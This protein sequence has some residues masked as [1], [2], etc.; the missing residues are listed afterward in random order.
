[1]AESLTLANLLI[2]VLAGFISFVSPCVLPLVPAFAAFLAST[3]RPR[4]E[5]EDLGAERRVT[6]RAGL[7][8]ILGFS[9]VFISLGASAPLVG[10]RLR[11]LSP[12][13]TRVGG[14]FLILLGLGMLGRWLHPAMEREYRI[15]PHRIAAT[16][17]GA[18]LIGITFAAGWTPCIGPVLAGILT[19]AASSDSSGQGAILL[20]AY[21]AGLGVP[22]LITTILVGRWQASPRRL[23]RIGRIG[24]ALAGVM[25]LVVGLL[26]VTDSWT[27][28]N[29]WLIDIAPWL[30]K[31]G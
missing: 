13:I 10:D 23:Q 18:F 4:G 26:L 22:F 24:Q 29:A 11:D 7:L 25:L 1:M 9:L 5:Q 30:T 31:I 3:I 28:L 2:A 12:W 19:L 17:L 14:A 15:A 27:R 21:S 6:L 8:F 20:A 16:P